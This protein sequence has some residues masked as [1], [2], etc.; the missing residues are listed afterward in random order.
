MSEQG[1]NILIRLAKFHKGKCLS[2]KF[3]ASADQYRWQCK[4]GHIWK[5]S[6]LSIKKGDWCPSCTPPKQK[7]G[8]A[9]GSIEKLQKIA[10]GKGGMILSKKYTYSADNYKWSCKEGH[11]WRATASIITKGAW[12]PHCAEIR[13]GNNKRLVMKELTSLAESKNGKCLSTQYN[14]MTSKYKWECEQ[15]H[16]WE[17]RGNSIKNGQWCRICSTI[18][19]KKKYLEIV[20]KR[21]GKFIFREDSAANNIFTWECEKGHQWEA[22]APNIYQGKWCPYCSGRSKTISIINETIKD[23]GWLCLD[24]QYIDMKTLM[25]FRCKRNHIK[26]TSW[27]EFAQNK[28]FECKKC[29]IQEVVKKLAHEISK[30]KHGRLVKN[31]ALDDIC[32]EYEFT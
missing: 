27:K 14:L 12:C 10:I 11:T 7:G 19:P 17:A 4:K 3:T 1:L 28:K 25:N 31:F 26:V 30:S 16:H 13:A 8:R 21:N 22:T 2:T 5:S 18:I 23:F 15:G 29:K 9:K 6:A 32:R 20:Q 24:E